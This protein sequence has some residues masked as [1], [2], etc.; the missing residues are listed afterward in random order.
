MS[1]EHTLETYINSL[2]EAM[3]GGGIK[4]MKKTRVF[5]E[6]PKTKEQKKKN[7]TNTKEKTNKTGYKTRSNVKSD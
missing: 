1:F 5:N 6:L 3:N 7:K 2:N 4:N